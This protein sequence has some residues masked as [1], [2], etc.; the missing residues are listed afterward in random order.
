M[1]KQVLVLVFLLITFNLFSQT[2]VEQTSIVLT[3][4]GGGS[5]AW[6]DYDNDGD[7][8]IFLTGWSESG[9]VSKIYRNNGDNS[10]TEKTGIVL[11]GVYH[12]SASWGDYDNDGDIDILL[13]GSLSS[14]YISKIYNNN[15]D[16]TFTEQTGIELTGL[17]DSSTD[18]GD[19]DNDGDQ[20][21]LLTGWSGSN[22]VSKIYSNNGNNSFTE[23]TG[24]ALTGVQRG[25]VSWGDYDNDGFLDVL[26]TGYNTSGT[27]ISKIYRNNID[28]SFTEQTIINLEG[29]AYSSVAWGDYN[30]DGY[31][32]VIMTG[33]KYPNGV[34]EIY[35]NN[36]DNTF[37][38][39]TGINLTG[40]Y[41]SSVAW[42]DYD[43]DGD[44]DI[45]LTG[46][47]GSGRCSKIYLNNGNNSFTEQTGIDLTGVSHSSAAWGDYDNDGDLDILLTGETGSGPVSKIYRNETSTPNVKPATPYNLQNIINNGTVTFIWDKPSDTE[48]QQKGLSYNLYIYENGQANYECPPY[49]FKQA[50]IKNGKRLIANPGNI[51]WSP[52]WYT[53][54]DLP[55]DKTYFWTVQAVDAGLQGSNF[56]AEQSFTV[57]FYRPVTQANCIALSN[58]QATQVTATWAN[59]GGNKR[60]VFI[61]AA[62]TGI[63]DLVD[64]TTYN[65]NDLTPNGWKCVYNGT[66]NSVVLTGLVQNTDYLLHV[67]EYNG[68]PGNENYLRTAVYQNPAV[69]NTIFGEWS[70]IKLTGLRNSSVA[71]GDYDNDGDLDILLTGGYS[72]SDRFSKIYR[73]NGDNNFAEQTDIVLKA[74]DFSS[75]AWGDYDNDG[76]L[77]ILLTGATTFDPFSPVS[78]IYRNDGS[79]S[80]TEQ[81]GFVLTGVFYS[82]VAWGDYN[83][84]GDLDILLT[85]SSSSGPVSKVYRNNGDNTFTEQIGI[86]LEAV[87][88]SSVAW[89]DYDN[90]GDPDILLTGHTGL[91]PVSKIYRNNG[92]NSFTEQAGIELPEVYYSSVTWGDYNNDGDL[93]ILLTGYTDSAYISKIYRNNGN[94]SFT[95]Q[96]GIPLAGVYI[97]STAWGDYDNDGD[98]DILLTGST[99]DNPYNPVSKIYRNNGDNS[100]TEQTGINLTK[101]NNSSVAWGDYDNDGDLDILLTGNS[102]SDIVSKL[103]RNEIATQNIKPSTP[104]GLQSY[105]D[106]NCIVFK[107]NKSSDNTT[108]TSAISYNLRIGTS[109]GGNEVKSGQ[110]L[111]NGKLL[112]PVINNLINDTCI[113][114]TLPLNKYYW[115][116]QAVDKGGLAS[117]FAS[118]EITPVD[119]IQAKD[120]QAF[121]KTSNSIL[122][123]WKNG[124]GLRRALFG[125]FS[126]SAEPAKP[127]NGTIYHAE[128]YFGQGD[129]IGATDWYCMYNGKA[130]STIIYGI[131]E[132]YSYDIQVFEYTE[133]NGLPEYFNTVGIGNPGIF[134]SSLYSEQTSIALAGVIESSVAFGDYDNDGYLD[135]LLTGHNSTATYGSV[136]ISKIYHNNGD[137]TF[138]EQTG[139]ALTGVQFSSVAW[140]D[141][142]NDSDLDILLTGYSGSGSVSKIYR[143]N[144][145]NSF[146]EQTDIILTGVY[147]SSV[148]WG[149][150]DNDGDLDI[151]L[152]G[153]AGDLAYNYNPVSKIYRNNGDNNFVEQTGILLT[154]VYW[155]SAAWG[156][157]DNDG[158]LD[159]LLTG[160]DNTNQSISKIYRN[161]GDNTFTEQ[162]GIALTEVQRGSVAWGDYD[163][164][165]DLDILLTG[166]GISKIYRNN[167]DNSFTEQTGLALTGVYSS[168]VAWGD[169]DND[170]DLD[171]LLTGQKYP[172]EL[173]KIYRNNGNNSFTEQTGIVLTGVYWSSIACKRIS[174]DSGDGKH[175][176]GYN[177]YN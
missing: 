111:A 115:S 151:L 125:R 60:A 9:P 22:P 121:I 78:K 99:D 122:I 30:N 170:G 103:F 23:Q 175:S 142:D 87:F 160:L 25:S 127:A 104:A 47:T 114:L 154:G 57:P 138:A 14:G 163:N 27:A 43:N 102:Y 149:D 164:D 46:E 130:D 76:D 148:S 120:L 72:Y 150:Y 91:K 77:D 166:S 92:D 90:D 38:R 74:V 75:V 139:I 146:T 12:G 24:I 108:P 68:A 168:S 41:Y 152:T 13:T 129:K 141:Y 59:G 95:E 124:N 135:I 134:S 113:V 6:G 73:N 128:P 20:D 159:I 137:N 173:S 18:W 28:N 177:F 39:Q 37:S 54:K 167:G 89:G 94:N 63:A 118:E 109:P 81:T 26:L 165:G 64:N 133:I 69:F 171:I 2:F 123:R 56:S 119:S 84:D 3:G 101:V 98:L 11:P 1:K 79:N 4:V 107:W 132:G 136:S 93:D 147:A 172:G 80:F 33:N 42:G 16:S 155:S 70:D 116:V 105:L 156:D 19:Y 29:V 145:N 86:A 52:S 100:F 161:N 48:T 45:L 140:G 61:K 49:A 44:L 110:S 8:D 143:N 10:F 71:W 144:G 32:D 15:G 82:S 112:L 40:V 34:S 153:S 35:Q 85:G 157:Y 53:I 88:M 65:V 97:S 117:S 66:A 36:G 55:P 106:N 126:S 96:T 158:D 51:Q 174:P 67:C 31:L 58:M 21:V 83:N 50:D 17:S 176:T 131:G 62:N 5:V 7:L 169:Y 162:S